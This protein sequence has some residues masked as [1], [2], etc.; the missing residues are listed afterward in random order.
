MFGIISKLKHQQAQ[1]F[2]QRFKIAL[3]TYTMTN[4]RF[5]ILL[6]H[7]K[8][9]PQ[10]SAAIAYTINISLPLSGDI[11]QQHCLFPLYLTHGNY[12]AF[13]I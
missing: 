11:R 8:A 10:A 4:P 5:L 13:A 3:K 2:L 12:K 7:T 9:I 6:D 1:V